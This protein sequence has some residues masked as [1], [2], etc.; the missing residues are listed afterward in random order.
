M[1]QHMHCISIWS[2][3]ASAA[4][5]LLRT[6]SVTLLCQPAVSIC[7]HCLHQWQNT[8]L[9]HGSQL[10]PEGHGLL[11]PWGMLC[12]CQ[13]TSAIL[14]STQLSCFCFQRSLGWAPEDHQQHCTAPHGGGST[15]HECGM[16]AE[17]MW[18]QGLFGCRNY[19]KPWPGTPNLGCRLGQRIWSNQSETWGLIWLITKMSSVSCCV[20]FFH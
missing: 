10:P 15:D 3:D 16:A 1:L 5:H 18:P 2:G 13:G 17:S 6:C 19:W 7:H 11:Q 14:P 20:G 4:A 8:A 9:V 12:I